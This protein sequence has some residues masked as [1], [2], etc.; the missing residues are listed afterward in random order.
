MSEKQQE[1]PGHLN[2]LDAEI[3]AMEASFSGPPKE[4]EDQ[5]DN[6]TPD[7]EESPV[8]EEEEGEDV[9]NDEDDSDEVPLDPTDDDQDSD[10]EEDEETSEDQD[11]EQ[12]TEPQPK[13]R[14]NDWKKR[15][16]NLRSH[17][18]ALVYDLRTEVSNLKASLVEVNKKNSEMSKL[19]AKLNEAKDAEGLLSEDERDL[20]GDETLEVLKKLTSKTVDP[21]KKQLEEERALR[22]KQ[23]EE[24]AKRSQMESQRMFV[25]RFAKLVPNYLEI[26]KDPKFLKFMQ[27]IDSASGYDRTTLFKRAVNNGDVVR[28]AGFYQEYLQKNKKVD[29]FAKKVT[30]TGNRSSTPKQPKQKETITVAYINQFYDDIAKGKYKGKA[31]LAEEIEM[32]IDKAVAEGRI[33]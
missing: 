30:P 22:L 6:N 27:D 19:L 26:D 10:D 13:R 8:V 31:S 9:D 33:R 4:Q 14:R 11:E 7:S 25:D 29:P 28:A 1:Q 12:E 21:I 18:D 2:D 20:I 23:Q 16:K 3:E 17:H 5:E 32:K 24:E 15:Y